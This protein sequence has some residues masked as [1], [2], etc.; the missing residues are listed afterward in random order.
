MCFYALHADPVVAFSFVAAEAI[1]FGGLD[2][3]GFISPW[4]DTAGFGGAKDDA[5]WAIEGTGHVAGGA[6]AS[7]D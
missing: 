2:D 6:F 7:H 5:E 3:F 4:S 1:G